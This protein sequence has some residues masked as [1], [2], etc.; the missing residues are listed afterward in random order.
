MAN[1]AS[2]KVRAKLEPR[3]EPYWSR[4]RKGCFLGYRALD[5]GAGTWIARYR[6]AA[7]RKQDYRAL[8]SFDD[9]KASAF[10][11]AAKVA[12]KF[13]D[14]CDAGIRPEVTTVWAACTQYIA[15]LRAEEGD[16]KADA[17]QARLTRL[18]KGEPLAS[19]QLDKLR[20]EHVRTWRQSMRARPARVDR[21]KGAEPVTRERAPATVNR[22]QVPLR[23]ALNFALAQGQVATAHAWRD[24]LKPIEGAD[25]RRELYLPAADRWRLLDRAESEVRPFLTGMT[26]LPL[27]PG[28]LAALTVASFDKR[29]NVIRVGDDKS[30]AG[31]AIGLPPATAAF[32][33]EQCKGAL[34]AA[35]LF[36]RA[37]GEAWNKDAWK[38]PIKTAARAAKLPRAVT[39]YTLRHS[40]ITDLVQSGLDLLTVA[41]ISGTSVAMIEKHYGH[42]RKEHAAAALA[43]LAM[44][45]PKQKAPARAKVTR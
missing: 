41:Q 3:R 28:A 15:H 38:K 25:R 30:G 6:N 32:I 17:E 4:I 33:A 8:G 14:D 27:R 43:T 45:V 39:A 26:L 19:I 9:G 12:A 36:R 35:P 20:P 21:T 29:L 16:T 18:V 2:R 42:L 23:A 24:A 22:D 40:T 1:L 10:D 5:H 7:E 34:P 31:R 37:N 11:Q 44:D 13:F